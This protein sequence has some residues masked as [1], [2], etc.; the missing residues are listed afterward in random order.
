MF[1]GFGTNFEGNP[2]P[3]YGSQFLPRKFKVAVTGARAVAPA[4]LLLHCCA[5][6]SRP[7]FLPCKFKVAVTG[8]RAAGLLLH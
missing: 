6:C 5:C 4:L 1:N 2:E 7:L 3:I 8:V